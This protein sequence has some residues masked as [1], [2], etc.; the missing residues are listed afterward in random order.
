MIINQFQKRA[1]VMEIT[2]AHNMTSSVIRKTKCFEKK[3]VLPQKISLVPRAILTN[4]SFLPSSYSKKI[5]WERGWHKNTFNY[6]PLFYLINFGTD[7]G[8]SKQISFCTLCLKSLKQT[9]K[10]ESIRLSHSLIHMHRDC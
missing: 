1:L 5:R 2:R 3:Y 7:H 8:F 10:K 4:P 9:I 6:L